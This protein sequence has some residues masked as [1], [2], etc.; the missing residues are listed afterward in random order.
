MNCLSLFVFYKV[1]STSYF[2]CVFGCISFTLYCIYLFA[3]HRWIL[4]FE[5]LTTPYFTLHMKVIVD[6]WMMDTGSIHWM[7]TSYQQIHRFKNGLGE[8][9]IVIKERKGC[10]TFQSILTQAQTQPTFKANYFHLDSSRLSTL[11]LCMLPPPA[12][13]CTYV[14]SL[15]SSHSGVCYVPR[16]P[17]TGKPNPSIHINSTHD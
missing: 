7:R 14:E 2:S 11:L 8:S 17:A 13:I 12:W 1:R 9:Y 6:G 3:M 10:D 4:D 5:Y 15:P 16:P